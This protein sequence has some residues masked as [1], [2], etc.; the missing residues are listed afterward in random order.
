MA[1]E[2]RTIPPGSLT[3]DFGYPN[4]II[5]WFMYSFGIVRVGGSKGSWPIKS[6]IDIDRII[7]VVFYRT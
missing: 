7:L 3:S 6:R 5:E 4:F 1:S 2:Q